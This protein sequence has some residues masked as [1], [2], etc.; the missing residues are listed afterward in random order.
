MSSNASTIRAIAFWSLTSVLLSSSLVGC[1]GHEGSADSEMPKGPS[2]IADQSATFGSPPGVTIRVVSPITSNMILPTGAVTTGWVS[3]EIAIVACKGEYEPASFVITAERDIASLKVQATDLRK[4]PDVIPSQRID[5]KV[6]KCWYQSGSAW[7]DINQDLTKR[8]LI[9]ELLLNDD[10]LIMVNHQAQENYL[11][12]DSPE[13]EKYIWISNPKQKFDAEKAYP[14]EK[15]PIRDSRLLLPVNIPANTNKQFWV[16]IHVPDDAAPGVYSG[17]I[18][19]STPS[20]DLAPLRLKLRVLPF[21]LSEPYY[22][23]GIF[24]R[25]PGGPDPSMRRYRK[26]M[27]NLIAHGVTSPLFYGGGDEGLRI[28][29]ELGMAGRPIYAI[30]SVQAPSETIKKELERYRSYGFTDVYFWAID[31]ASGERLTNQRPHWVR[32]RKAGG[33]VMATGSKHGYFEAMGDI[34]DLFICHGRPEAQEAA[35]WH[36][37]G[38]KIWPYAYPFGGVENPE[39]H[40]RNYG[41]VCWRANYDGTGNYAYRHETG[42]PYNDFDG[43]MRELNYVYT[44]IDGVIDTLAWEGCREAIDDVRYVTTLA[45]AIE[46]AMQSNDSELKAVA[47]D[48]QHYLDTLD[49]EQRNLNT[50]RLEMIEYLLKLQ[51]GQK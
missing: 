44:T 18:K 42:Y 47:A 17:H 16:T 13:G 45:Q 23:P 24:Y 51:D 10:Q 49:V 39:L 4:G 35:K 20:V 32:A 27:E 25:R 21:E 48:A 41:L 7:K 26:D 14:S 3:S 29:Q 1:A 19:L 6:V 38:Y 30:S 36:S 2:M 31:E 37:L 34:L 12:V 5:I 8:V 15:F 40:R 33:K 11:K 50:V 46:R 9:P 43:G 28:R 22:T